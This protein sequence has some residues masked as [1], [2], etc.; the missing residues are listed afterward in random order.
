[1]KRRKVVAML[2]ALSML[3]TSVAAPVPV[4]AEEIV[5]S[6]WAEDAREEVVSLEEE[7]PGEEEMAELLDLA[8]EEPADAD[9]LFEEIG[10]EE[11]LVDETESAVDMAELLDEG[12]SA[13]KTVDE[14]KALI[15]A[16]PVLTEVTEEKSAQIREAQAA[17]EAL[18]AQEQAAL[19][20]ET[21]PNLNTSQPYGRVLETAVWGLEVLKPVDNSTTLADGTYN[22]STTPALSSKYSKGKST[23]SR[24]KAWSVSEVTVSGGKATAVIKVESTSYSSIRVNGQTY[25]KTNT[26][27]NCEFAGVPI[28]LN[29]TFY[30]AAKS[31]SM[32]TEIAYSLTTTIE[33]PQAAAAVELT[34]TNKTTMFKAVSARLVNEE[35]QTWLVMALNSAGYRE[36][37][38]GT[39]EAAVANGDGSKDKGNDSWIHG[40]LNAEGKYEF[41]IPMEEGQL[42]GS[43][44]PLVAISN[45]YYGNYLNGQNSLGR[46]F[47]PRQIMV[48]VQAKTL[49]TGDLDMTRELAV[50]NHT[51]DL[52]VTKAQLNTVAGINSNNYQ[53][54]VILTLEGF[55]QAVI[56]TRAEASAE[57]AQVVP[58]ADGK[59]T[60]SFRGNVT[61]GALA[62]DYLEAAKTVSFHNAQTGSWEEYQLTVSKENGTILI[63][64]VPSQPA[65]PEE[66][67]VPQ[68]APQIKTISVK[69]VTST[70]IAAGK[71]VQLTANITPS[72]LA[73]KGVKWTSSN[74]KY[75]TV[76]DK[77][78]VTT[79]KAGAGKKVTITA[80][81]YGNKKASITIK[82]MK[83]QVTKVSI[84]GSKTVKAGKTVKLTARVTTKNGKANTKVRWTSS[85]PKVATVSSSG[86]VKGVKAGKVTITARALDGSGRKATIKITVKSAKKK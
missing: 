13:V 73:A 78:L 64:K 75:A 85:N 54:K 79:K 38:K 2:L 52:P 20:E 70:S 59:I 60:L 74:T 26:S 41:K 72:A 18:T 40:A 58:A 44:V 32:G 30:L 1:M 65:Q 49:V 8:A 36:L 67:P 66:K 53:E 22:V 46:A 15:E 86:K 50:T 12:E 25:D 76:N 84:S 31:S 7:V 68:P 71:K 82:I 56:G 11:L 4:M 16:L 63:D 21:S 61:G 45:T 69:A 29:S 80:T 17:Y 83:G 47:Y 3:A 23:S 55:D 9:D 6:D 39:F 10:E 51:V 57:G 48:D 5:V 77:G 33:E 24:D 42:D 34:I 62:Y 28:D 37:Y 35:G 14:V 81:G 19:D 43:L 27:G